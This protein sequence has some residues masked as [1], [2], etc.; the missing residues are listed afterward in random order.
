MKLIDLTMPL[1]EG[2]PVGYGSIDFKKHPSWPEA[3][4]MTE[5]RSYEPDGM[6]FHVYSIFCNTG[7]RLIMA[8]W[9]KDF[10]YDPTLDTVD[11]NKLILRD[12]VIIDMPKGEEEIIDPEDL[13]AAFNQAEV[14]KGDALLIRT[15]WGD[16]ERYL[17]MGHDYRKKGPHYTAL[18]ANKLMELL[19][20]NQSDMWLYDHV[21]MTGLDKRTGMHGGFTART[22]RMSVGGLVNTGAITNPRVKLL[23]LPLRIAD[24]HIAPCRVVAVEE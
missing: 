21:L 12:T 6:S 2:M 5:T 17:E 23:I 1:Y 18:S 16:N 20:K 4:K 8:S 11:I 19:T 24:A 14:Q 22:G 7:T 15:G 13:E 9:K 3:F 10:K